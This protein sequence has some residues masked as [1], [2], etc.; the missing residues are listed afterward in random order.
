MTAPRAGRWS[1][2]TGKQLAAALGVSRNS[3]TAWAEAGAP[4]GPPFDEFAW[5]TWAAGHAKEC[6]RAPEPELLAELAAAGV[7]PYRRAVAPAPAAASATPAL[8]GI[9]AQPLTSIE[10]YEALLGAPKTWAEAEKR[11]GVRGQLIRNA[12]M[13]EE[14]SIATAKRR[15]EILT[16]A[17]VLKRESAYD[18]A[19]L[20]Q[21]AALPDLVAGLVPA[22]QSAQA[23]AAINAWI[24][25]T[26]T[27]LAGVTA[28]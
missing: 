1:W 5:R 24:D 11:E 18:A 17:E 13:A 9:P 8:P 7:G 21:L 23:R 27:L 22:D 2:P 28:P 3:I 4:A 6:R 15:G 16:I 10:S 20:T 26:R 14:A 12:E 19:L 25:R